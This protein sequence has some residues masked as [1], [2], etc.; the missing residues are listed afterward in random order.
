MSIFWGA[1]P[2]G[3][4]RHPLHPPTTG[5]WHP[6]PLPP[7]ARRWEVSTNTSP[8]EAA[9][10]DLRGI[11]GGSQILFQCNFPNDYHIESVALGVPHCF[12]H[13]FRSCP[14]CH[15][16]SWKFSSAGF[17]VNAP[18]VTPA[19]PI[20]FSGNRMFDSVE[21]KNVASSF[22]NIRHLTGA[23]YVGNGWVAGGCCDC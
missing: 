12:E 1:G 3:Y 2:A 21:K 6:L 11:F 15:H 4:L 14:S 8:A 10:H 19:T 16:V 9:L 22:L 13:V 23:F 5:C 7:P 18:H 20:F 17:S